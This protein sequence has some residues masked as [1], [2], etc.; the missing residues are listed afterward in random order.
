MKYCT[1]KKTETTY[2]HSL[3]KYKYSSIIPS[4]LISVHLYIPAKITKYNTHNSYKSLPLG[5]IHN[6]P[7]RNK[8]CIL[9]SHF[10]L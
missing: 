3:L 1:L 2:F 5:K 8:T 9:K 6:Q 10:Y 4:L 7:K